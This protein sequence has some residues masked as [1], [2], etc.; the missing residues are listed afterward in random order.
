VIICSAIH[1]DGAM[2]VILAPIN[3]AAPVTIFAAGADGSTVGKF[4]VMLLGADRRKFPP[5]W[6]YFSDRETLGLVN[7]DGHIDVYKV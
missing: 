4:E 7:A 5:R 6:M 2:R 1:P 3:R